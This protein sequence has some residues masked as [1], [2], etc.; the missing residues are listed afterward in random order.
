ML[1]RLRTIAWDALV[2]CCQRVEDRDTRLWR[3]NAKA[4]GS[5]DDRDAT[6]VHTLDDAFGFIRRQIEQANINN[7]NAQIQSVTYRCQVDELVE[8][9]RHLLAACKAILPTIQCHKLSLL[10]MVEAAIAKA[11]HQQ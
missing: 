5:L 6:P 10:E 3:A 2:W 9:N 1:K 8:E 11:E 7:E 4:R